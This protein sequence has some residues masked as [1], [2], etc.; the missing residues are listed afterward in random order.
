MLQL[1]IDTEKPY[2]HPYIKK[3]F[4][5]ED[6]ERNIDLYLKGISKKEYLIQYI[7]VRCIYTCKKGLIKK[8]F[9]DLFCTLLAPELTENFFS[10][11]L[12]LVRAFFSNTLL[13]H[14]KN[15]AYLNAIHNFLEHLITKNFITETKS[16]HKEIEL[17]L[18]TV[19]G[20]KTSSIV[21]RQFI[22]KLLT[23]PKLSS[24]L[25][26]IITRV[27]TPPQTDV[28]VD[29]IKTHMMSNEYEPYSKERE[30]KSC[31][32]FEI[33]KRKRTDGEMSIQQPAN[34]SVENMNEKIIKQQRIA[35]E[36]KKRVTDDW[37]NS[38]LTF[39][40]NSPTD[41]IESTTTASITNSPP[42]SNTS[43]GRTI[44]MEEEY[45]TENLIDNISLSI[46][47]AAI[48]FTPDSNTVSNYYQLT[49]E[50]IPD[51]LKNISETLPI[52]IDNP[53]II[54]EIGNG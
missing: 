21:N 31:F 16:Y 48:I 52:D 27:L 30:I 10:E 42:L 39:P 3:K 47:S 43:L 28:L 12:K 18:R 23:L 20:F 38:I 45:K 41:I 53:L 9:Q 50:N 51:Y 17:I 7:H 34:L 24:E 54:T 13:A 35:N 15:E 4:P 2:S 19:L 36:L 26:E 44:S 37:I 32:K 5:K 8:K 11:Q 6:L 25:N 14:V 49:I 1:L 29:E 46:P 33:S 22:S 40:P